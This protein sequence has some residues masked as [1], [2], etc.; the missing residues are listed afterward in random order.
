MLAVTSAHRHGLICACF[1]LSGLAALIYQT[2]W[3]RQFALVFGTSELAVA[4]VLAAYMGGLALGARLVEALLPR[5]RRPVRVY[6][7]L[8][9]AIGLASLV[10]VPAGLWLAEWLLVRLLGGLSEPP[11][12][13][14]AGNTLFYLCAAFAILLIPTTLMGAT[15]PLLVRDDVHSDGEIGTRI[16]ML[17]ACNTAGAVVGALLTALLLLP[18]LGLRGTI[19]AAVVV[20]VLVSLLAWLLLSRG[21]VAPVPASAASANASATPTRRLVVPGSFWILPLM[22]MSGAVAFLHEVLWTRLLQRVVGSSIQSFG[23]MV[24]S[25][26]LGIAIGGALGAQLARSRDTAARAFAVSQFAVAVAAVGVWYAL[27]AW[28]GAPTTPAERVGLGLLLLLPLSLAIGVSYPLAVR[29]LATDAASAGAASARVYS[30]NTSGAIAG[31]LVGGFWLIPALRYEGTLQLAVWVSLALS[32]LAGTLLRSPAPRRAIPAALIL[33]AIAVLFRPQV[34][35][36]LLKMSMLR[37]GKGAIAYYD[38]GRSADVVVVRNDS[39]LDLRT[40]GLPEAGTPVLGAPPTANVETWMSLLAVLARPDSRKALIVG[41]GGGNV[42]QAVPP[43][44]EQIDVIELEPKVIAANRAIAAVRSH[45]PLT[46]AR[47]NLIYNDARGALA[48]SDQRYDFVVSQPSHPWTAGAS[49]LYTRE[50]MSQVK[51]HL[52]DGGVFVQWMGAEFTDAALM[53]SLVATLLDVYREVRVYRPSSTTILYLASDAPIQPER[54][55]AQTRAALDRAPRHYAHAGLNAAEDLIAALALETGDARRFAAGSPLITDDDNRLAMAN[56][57]ERK[58]GMSG[59]Q[60]AALMAP[61]DPLMQPDSFVYR[62]I[63]SDISFEY[64]WR[65]CVGWSAGSKE[66]LNRVGRM[67]QILGDSDQATLLRY[68]LA[69]RQQQPELAAGLLAAG[70]KRWPQS[71]MLRYADAAASLNTLAAGNGSDGHMSSVAA[72]TGEPAVVVAAMQAAARQQWG[73][74]A[75]VDQQLAQVPITEPWGPQA[76]QLRA[77]WRMRVKNAGLRQ[78]YGDEGIDIADRAEISQPDVFWHALRAL[79]AAGTN[80]PEVVVESIAAFCTTAD[81]IIAGL[82]N[83]ERR[84]V[85]ERAVALQGLLA[86]LQGDGRVDASRYE[87]VGERLAATAMRLAAP[88]EALP[89]PPG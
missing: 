40:N 7:L 4:T 82:S 58:L 69:V 13:G 20:N 60:V 53:R 57:Y 2:A 16:G 43:S 17:Y 71:V 38:V 5:I 50:F 76:E 87:E 55:L 78:R 81:S 28:V 14:A 24:A 41:F 29:V 10:M 11:S 75:E 9:L 89:M 23:V 36:Q 44:V 86:Q 33:V 37:S 68:M 80:R 64:L 25:F 1:T 48:L 74:V 61:Y 79:S 59:D 72:L 85:R 52:S 70:L 54:Q 45:D 21:E 8:E 88:R 65:R 46:D 63:A 42:V 77:E 83:G 51:R 62:E 34:P 6:A 35:E 19:R 47:L 67:T 3:T 73:A 39:L 66:A 18:S 31:A 27:N 56:V 32:L 26:L 15:L 12:S 22:F 30:W 49:H 84:L